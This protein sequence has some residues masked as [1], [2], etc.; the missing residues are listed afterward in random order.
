MFERLVGLVKTALYKVL[1]GAKLKFK[2]LQGIIKDIQI[3]LNNRP[4]SYCED[5]IQQPTLTPS[6]MIFG[7]EIHLPGEN[8]EDIENQDLRKLEKYLCRCKDMLWRSFR[9]EYLNALRE[10]HNTIHQVKELEVKPGDVVIIKDEK[11]NRGTWKIG[12]VESLITGTDG[13]ARAVK[14][15]AGKSYLERA[16]QHLYPLELQCQERPRKNP[17]LNA[18]AREIRPKRQSA[19]NASAIIRELAEDEIQE[20]LNFDYLLSYI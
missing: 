3:I 10:R 4:L 15:Q 20:I 12:V 16:I 8:L 7:R 1:K 19:A 5:D 2:E 9:S 17:E 14:P 18:Q 6:A 11:K 13:V